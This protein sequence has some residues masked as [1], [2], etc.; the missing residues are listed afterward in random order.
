MKNIFLSII[1]SLLAITGYSTSR[2]IEII[3]QSDCDVYLQIRG[4][5]Q[6]PSCEVEFVS[7]LMVI[8]AGS[9]IIHPNTATICNFPAAP[10]FVHS[11]LIFAGPR[12]CPQIQNWLIGDPRCYPPETQ[13]F[14]LNQ[15]CE[16]RCDCLR[17]RWMPADCDGIARLI[18]Q[19][20]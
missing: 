8:P 5:R 15:N 9:S 7:C 2:G 17:A 13:F 6:C 10:A 3:N 20:C 1:L 11:A 18:I 19:P 4:S 12:Q 16:R 14:S